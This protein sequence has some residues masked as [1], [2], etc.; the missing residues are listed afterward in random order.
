MNRVVVPSSS[1]VMPYTNL[2]GCTLGENVFVGPFVEIQKGAVIGNGTRISSHSFVCSGV[3]I[4]A[5][6]FVG[7]GVMFVN[8]KFDAPLD[9]WIE[10]NTVIGDNVRIGSNSTILP[11]RIGNHVVI[12]A[13]S[14]VTRDVP[15]YAVVKGVPARR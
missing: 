13:G 8:D 10:R 5:G 14:V 2:Y 11:V 1:Q 15:D 4:G 7:H 12:G 3:T 6:C 9:N